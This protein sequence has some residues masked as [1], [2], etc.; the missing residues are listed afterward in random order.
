[1]DFDQLL[2]AAS[3]AMSVPESMVARSARARA[4]AT[5]VTPEQ[6]LAEWAGV[7]PGDAPAAPAA[8]SVEPAPAEPASVEPASAEPATAPPPAAAV[9]VEVVAPVAATA[10]AEPEPEPEPDEE[11][12]E[13]LF[14]SAGIRAFKRFTLPKWLTAA[15]VVVPLA[16]LFYAASFATG[17]E[18]GNGGALGVDPVTGIAENCD[19][20]EFG[21]V[22]E[23]PL[24]L[25]ATLYNVDAACQACHGAA[26]GGGAGPALA[27]GAVTETFPTC[28]DHIEWVALGT[29]GWGQERGPTYGANNKTVGGFGLMPGFAGGLTPQEIAAVVFYERVTFGGLDAAA[30][31][32]DCFASFEAIAAN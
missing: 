14:G 10:E 22:G 4:S 19:G 26:G 15:F 9:D 30:A 8:T 13:V 23:D 17:P 24:I 18:C 16:A 3:Q 21:F 7:D 32:T 12:M 6:I 11:P 31:E 28:D 5:G 20:S 27:S 2:S 1:M 25:G 29:T